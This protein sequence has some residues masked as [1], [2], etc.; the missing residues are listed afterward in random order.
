MSR[1]SLN[2]RGG[3]TQLVIPKN[4]AERQALSEEDKCRRGPTMLVPERNE[5]VVN[6]TL[7]KR[8]TAL[9]H[10]LRNHR[11][12]IQRVFEFSHRLDALLRYLGA[13]KQVADV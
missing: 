7:K 5:A 8:T 9:I 12:A 1:D 13:K 11:V 2:T 4:G 3:S 10:A 6:I